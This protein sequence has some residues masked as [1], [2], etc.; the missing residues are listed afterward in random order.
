[1]SRAGPPPLICHPGSAPRIDDF[2][3]ECPECGAFWDLDNLEADSRYTD[4]YPSERSHFDAT[5]GALKVAT[6]ER[7]LRDTNLDPA[8]RVVCE[9]GFGG[10]HCLR[11]LHDHARRAYGIE[12]IPA[13]VDH[14]ATLGVPRD[15]M[16]LAGDLPPVLPEPVQLWLFQDCLEHLLQ[17]DPFLSWLEK[18]SAPD[19]RVLVVAPDGASRSRRLLGRSW[20]HRVPDHAFHWT[21]AGMRALLGRH[22]FE[23]ER[24][25]HPVKRI[26]TR[27]GVLHLRQT[28]LAPIT[29][30]FEWLVPPAHLWFN[31]GELGMVFRR[32]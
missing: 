3:A 25:F 6:L 16:F 28:R 32:R 17:P 2:R 12:T 8:S 20:P 7:W 9:I 24:S 15:R 19:A 31:I 13:D 23:F 14:A 26:S 27:M 11:Y 30:A 4:R 22:G 18:S 1:M 21:P 10:G 29:R 5:V